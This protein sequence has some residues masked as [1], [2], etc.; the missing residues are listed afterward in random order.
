[1]LFVERR[2]VQRVKL[3]EPLRG[4]A[5]PTRVFVIDVS[6]NGV[7]IAHQEPIGNIGS[8]IAVV[9]SWDARPMK[10]E[11]KIVRTAIHRAADSATAKTL[12]HSGL[13]ITH[14]DDN[15]LATLRELIHRHILRALDEQ[16]A[17]AR[18]IPAN[19]PQSH[20]RSQPVHYRRHELIA[21]RWRETDT[22]DPAQ[23]ANG[24]TVAAS[25]SPEEV[26]MLRS[27]FE[28]ADK[29]SGGHDLIRRMA[30]LSITTAEGIP[31]RRFMP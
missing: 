25:H 4:S 6:L 7:R 24:F 17:N 10:L 14:A 2:R 27:A 13:V 5:G 12:Y 31:S 1:M 20:Q 19:A 18:G 21:G 22:T 28:T 8:T 26:T 23:P 29:A 15:S 9:T 16:K 11:C 30:K 3:L